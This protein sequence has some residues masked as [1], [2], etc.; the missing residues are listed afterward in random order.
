MTDMATKEFQVGD[1]VVCVRSFN[2]IR[3]GMTGTICQHKNQSLTG[4]SWGI[5]WDEYI[6]GHSCGGRCRDGYGYR[7]QEE[8][9]EHDSERDEEDCVINIDLNSL[10]FGSTANINF[11]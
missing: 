7:L 5:A 3:R 9:I 11:M 6:E 1:R 4:K 2:P 8:Y 10:L